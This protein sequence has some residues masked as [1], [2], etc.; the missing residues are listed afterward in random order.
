MFQSI[1]KNIHIN[2]QKIMCN[3]IMVIFQGMVTFTCL[4][5]YPFF[6]FRFLTTFI[7]LL[8]IH[9]LNTGVVS[10]LHVCPRF[11]ECNDLDDLGSLSI[12]CSIPTINNLDFSKFEA[13]AT[14]VLNPVLSFF[15]VVLI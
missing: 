15:H 1:K 7:L 5:E 11:C 10:G 14:S 2:L 6:I 12:T 3:C 8:I 4:H 9:Q 13:N